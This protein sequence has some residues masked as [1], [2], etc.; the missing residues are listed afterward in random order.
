MNM[1]SDERR[2]EIEKLTKVLVNGTLVH[3]ES[4]SLTGQFR[5]LWQ[6]F[7][8][9]LYLCYCVLSIGL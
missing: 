4:L 1:N 6:C 9:Y 5:D 2:W 7:S 8:W 3:Y